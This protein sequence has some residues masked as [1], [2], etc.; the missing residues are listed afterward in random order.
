MLSHWRGLLYLGMGVSDETDRGVK[1]SKLLILLGIIPTKLNHFYLSQFC[2]GSKAPY[3]FYHLPVSLGRSETVK[4]RQSHTQKCDS[5]RI[6]G[7]SAAE[8][9]RCS[10]Q[11]RPRHF[12]EWKSDFESLSGSA[13][14]HPL[15]CNESQFFRAIDDF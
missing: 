4:N 14:W 6:N 2:P 11:S 1:M 9:V 8:S 7:C 13:S 12:G 10:N 5:L 3:P 15:V